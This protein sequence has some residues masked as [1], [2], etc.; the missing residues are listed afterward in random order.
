M[1]SLSIIITAILASV[2][3][4]NPVPS[5][6]WGT[7][8]PPPEGY[9]T[10]ENFC[11]DPEV[12]FCCNGTTLVGVAGEATSTQTGCKCCFS[13]SCFLFSSLDQIFRH[14]VHHHD[15]SVGIPSLI[16]IS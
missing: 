7:G 8:G 16:N 10:I 1:K 11:T 5:N 15:S 3:L 4:A 9:N 12:L 13:V 6:S 2:S 14:I